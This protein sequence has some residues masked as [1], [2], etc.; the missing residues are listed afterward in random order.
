M[1]IVKKVLFQHMKKELSARIE[2]LHVLLQT[3]PHDND[4]IEKTFPGEFVKTVGTEMEIRLAI[5]DISTALAEF[6]RLR[7]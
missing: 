6:K 5:S 2:T 4:V 7:D 3:N 1:P